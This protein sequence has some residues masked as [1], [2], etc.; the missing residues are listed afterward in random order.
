MDGGEGAAR[1]EGAGVAGRQNMP[2]YGISGDK[3]TLPV[4]YPYSMGNYPWVWVIWLP[5]PVQ[6]RVAIFLCKTRGYYPWV[7]HGL[8]MSSLNPRPVGPNLPDY[9]SPLKALQRAAPT[10]TLVVHAQSR[11]MHPEAATP[12]RYLPLRNGPSHPSGS[13]ASS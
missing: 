5:V 3:S 6:V 12:S 13:N 4:G 8:P 11:P 7:T 2:I 1:K 10:T 9:L